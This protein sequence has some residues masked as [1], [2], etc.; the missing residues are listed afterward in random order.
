M[1]YESCVI[2]LLFLVILFQVVCMKT[3]TGTVKGLATIS[4]HLAQNSSKQKCLGKA[5]FIVDITLM[6]N[7]CLE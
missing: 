4:R 5:K 1:H 2:M 6:R 3:Q 7:S